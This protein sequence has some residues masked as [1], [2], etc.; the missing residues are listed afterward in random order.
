VERRLFTSFF[1]VSSVLPVLVLVAGW[2]WNLGVE[3][4]GVGTLLGPEGSSG[5]VQCLVG[6]PLRAIASFEPSIQRIR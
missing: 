5:H 4:G 3:E 1:D 6:L 2:V